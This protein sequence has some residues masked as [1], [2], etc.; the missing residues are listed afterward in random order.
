MEM[1]KSI[2]ENEEEVY[3]S[4]VA[5]QL[6]WIFAFQ[7]AINSISRNAIAIPVS[8]MS[9]VC[10][11][12]KILT[13][14]QY[15]DPILDVIN[16]NSVVFFFSIPMNLTGILYMHAMLISST[17]ELISAWTQREV[18]KHEITSILLNNT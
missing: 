16:S 6:F 15:E 10:V 18:L 11:T 5:F 17:N 1:L 9:S 3:S 2:K 7:M 14:R 4:L 8:M 12:M 13:S